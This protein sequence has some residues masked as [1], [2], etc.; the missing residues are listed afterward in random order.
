MF[1]AVFSN[2]TPPVALACLVG[3]GIA[4]GDYFKTAFIGFKIALIAFILPYLIIWNPAVILKG[5]NVFEEIMTVIAILL[6]M[7]AIG[8]VFTNYYIT[9]I[10]IVHRGL[11]ALCAILFLGYSF[12]TNFVYF[13]VGIA[14]MI[15]L[16]LD[17]VQQKKKLN[18]SPN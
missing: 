16:T 18:L 8:I 5:Q 9:R 11:F 17:Q 10:H 14:L 3:S 15:V 13:A 2:L 4:G 6:S 1:F 12:T 7:L